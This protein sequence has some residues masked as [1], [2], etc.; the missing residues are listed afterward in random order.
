MKNLK[1]LADRYRKLSTKGKMIT[2]LFIAILA[3]IVLDC[4]W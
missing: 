2:V 4:C 3:I 1:L